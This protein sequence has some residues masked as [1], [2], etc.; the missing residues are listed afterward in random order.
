MMTGQQFTAADPQPHQ[1][2]VIARLFGA[3]GA[4]PPSVILPSPIGETGGPLLTG[5]FA[6]YLGRVRTVLS[7]RRAADDNPQT[8]NSISSAA[9]RAFNLDLEPDFVRRATAAAASGKTACWP[10]V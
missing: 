3:R 1:G 9:T 7:V 6:A 5:Q 4:A 8:A 10:G 2:S